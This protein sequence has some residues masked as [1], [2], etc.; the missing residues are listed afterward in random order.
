V[1]GFRAAENAE[2][3]RNRGGTPS[4]GSYPSRIEEE[5]KEK[6]EKEKKKNKVSWTTSS[7]GVPSLS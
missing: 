7:L 5:A 1:L 2:E 4:K 6:R 3:Q